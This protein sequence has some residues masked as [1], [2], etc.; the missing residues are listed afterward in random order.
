MIFKNEQHILKLIK[1]VPSAFIILL[2]IIII[3]TLYFQNNVVFQ[4][5][6]AKLKSQYIEKNK[7]VIQEQVNSV[8]EFIK[9][10]RRNTEKDLKESLHEALHNAHAVAM[11]IYN[12]NRHRS[13]DDVKKLIKEA[14]RPITFNSGR[15]YFFIYEKSGKNVLLPYSPHL[16]GRNLLNHQDAKGS[17]IIQD[18]IK[19]LAHQ[20]ELFYE[21]YWFKPN[22]KSE[23]K[24]KVGYYKNFKPFNWFIGTGE[25]I[26]DFEQEIQKRLLEH[27]QAIRFGKNG[28][29]FV[30]NYDSTY[31]SHI[32]PYFIGKSAAENKDVVDVDNV[33]NDLIEIAKQGSGFYTYIQ[34]KKINNDKP[35]EKISFV[36]GLSDWQWMIGTGFYT[37]DLNIEI[38][39][40]KAL[41]DKEFKNNIRNITQLCL[42]VTIILLMLSFYFSKMLQAKFK[43]YTNEIQLHLEENQNQQ[44]LLSQQSKMAAMGEMIGNI[45]HQWRQP[46]STITTSATGMQIQQELKILT[47]ESI[48]EGLSTINKSAQYLSTTIDDFRNFFKVNK[49]K[50]HFNVCTCIEQAISLVWVQFKNKEIHIIQDVECIEI[51]NFQNELIQV[52]INL[53]NNARDELIKKHSSFNKLIFI[54][55]KE[56]NNEAVLGI[57]DNAGGIPEAIIG[58]IFE[59]YFTTKHKSQ[60]TGIGLYM[61]Q[62]IIQKNME[63]EIKVSNRTYLYNHQ[64]HQGAYFEIRLPLGNKNS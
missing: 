39:N 58:R 28:Y 48:L 47:N 2:S 55:L 3:S 31:L 9:R 22:D 1:Y 61:C 35:I 26:E 40:K 23:Q 63:G 52:I 49:E 18:V 29:I 21:W 14:I 24:R 44:T 5:E 38:E 59:P 30:L 12:E 11:A 13:E 8:F 25:Y 10:E 15:G 17:Y 4:Q 46:L 42:L 36:K 43:N 19:K 53:L 54:T 45:A 64:E 60:G 57:Q 6:K 20:D 50:N 16:E 56:E 34:T 7:Q 27:I 37:D 33:I 62:E 32:R 41:L 51:Y